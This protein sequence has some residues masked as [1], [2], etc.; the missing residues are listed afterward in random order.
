MTVFYILVGVESHQAYLDPY[1]EVRTSINC[2]VW[3]IH[4]YIYLFFY[5]VFHFMCVNIKSIL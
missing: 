4:H 2:C 3:T 5:N 1:L